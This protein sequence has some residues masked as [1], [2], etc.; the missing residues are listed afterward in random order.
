MNELKKKLASWYKPGATD[1]SKRTYHAIR[2]A[3]SK[4]S[5]LGKLGEREVYLQGSY[6]NGTN[7]RGDS[8]VDVVVQL[9]VDVNQRSLFLRRRDD[10]PTPSNVR[11]WQNFRSNVSEALTAEFGDGS[12][13]EHRKALKVETPY[14]PADVVVALRFRIDPP[15]DTEGIAMFL[16]DESRWVVNYPKRH[17]ANGAKKN[18]GTENRYKRMV[19]VFKNARTYLVDQGV[20]ANGC[21]PSYFVECLLFNVP[22]GHFSGLVVDAFPRILKYLQESDISLFVC[23]NRMLPLFGPLSEQWNEEDA[24]TLLYWLAK[25]WKAI[26]E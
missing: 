18:Q 2:R 3:L 8:D 21:A 5:E 1:G 25:L 11:T 12:V 7:I 20:L 4:S 23:Q 9:N 14:L 22:G 17:Y 6:R 16:L 24:R 26:N 19:R 15:R 10:M 13:T